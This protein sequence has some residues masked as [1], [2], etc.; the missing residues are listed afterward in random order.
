MK[1][2]DVNR[3]ARIFDRP[4]DPNAK[5]LVGT[6]IEVITPTSFRFRTDPSPRNPDGREYEFTIGIEKE[7]AGV[8]VQF[9]DG[10]A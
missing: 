4:N 10:D 2:T 5:G 1:E 3:R 7:K 8:Q 9:L 6:I